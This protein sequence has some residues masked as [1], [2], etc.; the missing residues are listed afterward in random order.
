MQENEE[1]Y[2][3]KWSVNVTTGAPLLLL[4]GKRGLLKVLDT[5]TEALTRVSTVGSLLCRQH[6]DLY[7]C[8]DFSDC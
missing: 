4:A 5:E 6:S 8:C 2:A 7:R 3:V 1:F